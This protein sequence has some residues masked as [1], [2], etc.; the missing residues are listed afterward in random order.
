MSWCTSRE[1][2]H[3]SFTTDGSVYQI[4]I[5]QVAPFP[6]ISFITLEHI[7]KIICAK[8]FNAVLFVN[9]KKSKCSSIK[10]KES[11]KGITI[12]LNK[13][14]LYVLKGNYIHGIVSDLKQKSWHFLN[15]IFIYQFV[16]GSAGSSL[17]HELFSSCGEQG[18][19][20][21]CDVWAS[22]CGGFSCCGAQALGHA[23]LSSC[24]MWAQQ[25]WLPGS[26]PQA[27]QLCCMGL[28]APRHVGSPQTR[29]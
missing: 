16:F 23:G 17:L 7:C 4:H 21:S 29:G 14:I 10:E 19:L 20:S 6:G 2:M 24:G 5:Q 27:Q 3:I 18:P 11:I 8:M 28:V 15:F 9:E 1:E 12:Q 26:R 22:R 25:L 13:G